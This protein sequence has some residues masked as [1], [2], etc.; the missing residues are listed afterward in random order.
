MLALWNYTEYLS[1]SLLTTHHQG[2]EDAQSEVLL[3]GESARGHNCP[4]TVSSTSRF[5]CISKTFWSSTQFRCSWVSLSMCLG[6]NSQIVQCSSIGT[7]NKQRAAS[8]KWIHRAIMNSES[9]VNLDA[10]THSCLRLNQALHPTF[11]FEICICFL[12]TC[13]IIT[14]Q[15]IWS[16]LFT[17]CKILI[18]W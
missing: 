2:R 15:F 7:L 13:L 9:V 12:Y 18:P 1:L 8:V 10:I 17:P 3:P 16:L 5:P 6:F 4:W 14:V 11:V